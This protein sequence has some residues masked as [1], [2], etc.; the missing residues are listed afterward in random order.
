MVKN[1]K[2]YKHKTVGGLC[3]CLMRLVARLALSKSSKALIVELSRQALRLRLVSFGVKHW[4]SL[5]VL[6]PVLC[7]LTL[8]TK[9]C[10]SKS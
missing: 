3:L 5:F 1:I 8:S 7:F 2:I 9:T 4:P 6:T 10:T